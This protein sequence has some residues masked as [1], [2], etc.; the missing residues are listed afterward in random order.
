MTC[1]S[2]VAVLLAIKMHDFET[3]LPTPLAGH[4]GQWITTGPARPFAPLAPDTM[5]QCGPG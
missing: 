2:A 3:T 4:I 1:R 5:P